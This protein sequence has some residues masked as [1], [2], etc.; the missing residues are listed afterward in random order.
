MA[1][2]W[3]DVTELLEN[4]YLTGIQ[5]I[6]RQL[7]W[8]WDA[9][10]PLVPIV[11]DKRR[12]RFFEVPGKIFS[13]CLS[14]R[15][16]QDTT[17]NSSLD[18][19]API[20]LRGG[21]LLNVEGFYCRHRAQAYIDAA[22]SG[23]SRLFWIAM[24]FLPHLQP[25]HFYQGAAKTYMPYIR[26]LRHMPHVGF[27][28][29]Q[30]RD[31]FASRIAKRP[32]PSQILPLGADALR[33]EPQRFSTDRNVFL[34]IGT[35]EPRKRHAELFE[36]FER[37]WTNG[38]D[39]ELHVVGRVAHEGSS[40]DA[41]LSKFG[42]W[43]NFHHHGAS[44]D[45][46]IISLLSRAR[47]TIFLSEAEGFGLPPLESLNAGIPVICASHG[48]PSLSAIDDKGQLRLAAIS[49]ETVSDAVISMLNDETAR[50]L[51]A[52]AAAQTLPTWRDFARKVRDWLASDSPAKQFV[53]P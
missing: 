53:Q 45:E 14:S 40:E 48:V 37:L 50:R 30:T 41:L 23:H 17:P 12:G 10:Y 20:D 4:P 47:A 21:T 49:A 19:F 13:R 24:D 9:R 26:A 29:S 8:N 32:E 22:R 38:L 43:P 46:T 3:F 15:G 7:I 39:C 1:P 31:E 18:R 44:S 34:A 28:S 51:W 52:E 27:I 6:Q 16:A 33:I 11:F 36:A 5:R 25:E 35:I 42:R 2:T